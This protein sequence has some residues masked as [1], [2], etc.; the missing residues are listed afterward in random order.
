M[1]S[2]LFYRKGRLAVLGVCFIAV[3]GLAALETLPR[4]EDPTLSRRFADV[5]TLYPGAT[6]DRVE[7]LI[8][9]KIESHLQEI[10]EIALI[11]SIS[12]TGQSVVRLELEEQ[13][14]ESDVDEIWS[15]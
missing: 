3:A 14:D 8:S 7:A 11:E 6:A 9:E 5:V 1:L 10:H 15:R 2:D 12:R 4:Q 13:Y